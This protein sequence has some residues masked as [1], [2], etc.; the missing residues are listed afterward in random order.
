M[1]RLV[2]FTLMTWMACT[3]NAPV[4]NAPSTSST[5]LAVSSPSAPLDPGAA[6]QGGA[7]PQAAEEAFCSRYN[8][9][10]HGMPNDGSRA[11]IAPVI[12]RDLDGL[13]PQVSATQAG[14]PAADRYKLDPF[15]APGH[16]SSARITP[17]PCV[18]AGPVTATCNPHFVD[19]QHHDSWDDIWL[20]SKGDDGV[21]R[22]NDIV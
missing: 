6:S 11:V 7:T 12:T 8:I 9:V 4:S 17:G 21:W 1:N 10:S 13:L 18:I 20:F 15:T 22:L 19:D 5:P 16:L 2:S 14:G 3:P